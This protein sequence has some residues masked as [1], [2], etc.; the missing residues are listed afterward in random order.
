M[1]E[2]IEI[3]KDIKSEL[4]KWMLDVRRTHILRSF[5]LLCFVKIILK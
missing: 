5:I 3:L 4:V 2:N 1:N